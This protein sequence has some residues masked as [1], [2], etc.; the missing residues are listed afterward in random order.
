MTVRFLLEGGFLGVVRGSAKLSEAVLL[1]GGWYA[2]LLPAEAAS[3]KRA[4]AQLTAA[5]D[6]ALG[7]LSVP[8]AGGESWCRSPMAVITETVSLQREAACAYAAAVRH[9]VK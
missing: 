4:A 1:L 8:P 9:S 5:L 6:L 2:S 7:A 3:V